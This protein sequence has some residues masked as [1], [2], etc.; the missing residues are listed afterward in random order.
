MRPEKLLNGVVDSVRERERIVRITGKSY[1]VHPRVKLPPRGVHIVAIVKDD[2]IVSWI[3]ERDFR[4][5]RST[6]YNK[7]RE[8]A[9]KT[10]TEQKDDGDQLLNININIDTIRPEVVEFIDEYLG[11]L[12]RMDTLAPRMYRI[13]KIELS[14]EFFKEFRLHE[15]EMKKLEIEEFKVKK[16]LEIESALIKA[17]IKKLEAE[18]KLLELQAKKLELEIKDKEK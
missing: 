5:D 8:E 14:R 10:I 11:Q 13:D 17:Q 1:Y 18:A 15:R 7:L 12:N 16:Q 4:K 2:V 6:A 9:D 3:D